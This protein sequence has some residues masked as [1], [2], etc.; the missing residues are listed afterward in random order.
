MKK[1]LNL[2]L[3]F[4]PE[5]LLIALSYPMGE[6]SGMGFTQMLVVTLLLIFQNAS[7]TIVS[8][9]RQSANIKLHA[10]AAIGSN[11]FFIFIIATVAAHY[12]NLPLKLWYIVCTVVGSVH[13]H[14]LSLHKI[15]K[16]KAFKNDSLV[17]RGEFQQAIQKHDGLLSELGQ[18]LEALQP[19]PP[20]VNKATPVPVLLPLRAPA[21]RRKTGRTKRWM[22]RQS[23]QLELGFNES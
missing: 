6:A 22:L 5:L 20:A 1:I 15:E 2:L 19:P 10:I 16:A 21:S 14:H 12:D 11:G 18:K 7:F 8:R 23:G 3:N 13:A 17:T 4:A 9:A